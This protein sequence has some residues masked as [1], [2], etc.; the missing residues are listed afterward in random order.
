MLS[1]FSFVLRMWRQFTGEQWEL[2]FTWL[3][4]WLFSIHALHLENLRHT[5]RKGE[6]HFLQ[7]D[8]GVTFTQEAVFKTAY[9]DLPIV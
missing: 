1:L 6:T 9:T 5:W 2:I 4:Q 3:S 7:I 8:V